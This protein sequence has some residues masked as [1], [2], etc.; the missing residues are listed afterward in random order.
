V[1]LRLLTRLK[2]GS[3]QRQTLT[4]QQEQSRRKALNL[5]R[6]YRNPKR[7]ASNQESGNNLEK[8]PRLRFDLL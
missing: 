2:S 6:H 3:L 4:T 1:R 7:D 5:L 8:V